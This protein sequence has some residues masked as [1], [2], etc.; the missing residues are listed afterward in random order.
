MHISARESYI[1]ITTEKYGVLQ[2]ES[3][4]KDGGAIPGEPAGRLL[5]I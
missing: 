1:T 4:L 2:G 3:W 5:K